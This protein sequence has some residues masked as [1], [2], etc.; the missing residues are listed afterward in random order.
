MPCLDYYIKR[1]Q[2]PCVGYIDRDEYR[3]NIEAIMSFLSGRYREIT[4]DLEQKMEAASET[5]RSSSA[6]RSTATG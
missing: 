4:R 2:A 1:C 3:R 5:T 6:R